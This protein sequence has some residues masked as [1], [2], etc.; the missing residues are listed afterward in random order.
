MHTKHTAQNQKTVTQSRPRSD[1]RADCKSAR[2]ET[3]HLPHKRLDGAG[4]T[5]MPGFIQLLRAGAGFSLVETI[6]ACG[7]LLLVLSTIMTAI[8]T[9]SGATDQTKNQ[10]TA[11]YLAQDAIEYMRWDRDTVFKND[12]KKFKDFRQDL[13]GCQSGKCRLDTYKPKTGSDPYIKCG[14][15]DCKPL[16]FDDGDNLYGYNNGGEK[17]QFTR[18]IKIQG[19]NS[20]ERIRVKVTVKID[21]SEVD[22][23]TVTDY[24]YNWNQ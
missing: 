2:S 9:S 1:G 6:V 5:S 22:P 17:S 20:N 11:H 8:Y 19:K 4:K 13:N 10:I 23:V 15:S 7:L 3:Q 18:S 24:L 12:S 21:D 14:G 16:K